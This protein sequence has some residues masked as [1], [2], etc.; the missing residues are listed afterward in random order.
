MSSTSIG[1]LKEKYE[2]SCETLYKKNI[3]LNDIEKWATDQDTIPDDENGQLFRI[4]VKNPLER[5][6]RKCQDATVWVSL[7]WFMQVWLNWAS[8]A[9]PFQ[10]GL[11]CRSC[12]SF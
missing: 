10:S 1:E 7:L 3:S 11:T 2:S 8:G 6:L 12:F 9:L 4:L 5:S